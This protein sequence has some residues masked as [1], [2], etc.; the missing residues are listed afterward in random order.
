MW[1]LYRLL[2]KLDPNH[3]AS[4]ERIDHVLTRWKALTL[5]DR[6]GKPVEG[7]YTSLT[8]TDEFRWMIGS[9]YGHGFAENKSLQFGSPSSK[10]IALRCAFYGRAPLSIPEMKAG[11]ARDKDAYVF[12]ALSNSNILLNRKQRELFEQEQLGGRMLIAKHIRNFELL[13]KE[14]PYLP[15]ISELLRDTDEKNVPNDARLE[16]IESAT[17][18]LQAKIGEMAKQ[19]QLVWLAVVIGVGVALYYCFWK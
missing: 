4:P 9:L 1:C 7:R 17:T 5:N 11:Y 3:A 19:L 14:R 16:R 12:A 10:D 13:K 8:A 2:D 6:K 15:A 18:G